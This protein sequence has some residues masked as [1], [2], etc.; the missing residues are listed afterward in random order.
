[1]R[2]ARLTVL[3]E[4]VFDAQYATAFGFDA[5]EATAG[6]ERRVGVTVRGRF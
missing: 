2:Q 4:N 3:A 1:V 5:T 6:D